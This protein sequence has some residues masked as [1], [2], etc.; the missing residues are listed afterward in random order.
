MQ[1]HILKDFDHAMNTLR[2]EVL[3][4]A[5]LA[6]VNLERAMQALFDRNLELA[7]AVIADDNEVDELER[8]VDQLG[9]DVLVRFHPVASDLRL[10][11]TAMKI[12]MN[13]ER[14]SDHAVNIAKR[15]RK[16]CATPVLPDVNLLEPLYTLADHLLRDAISAFSDRNATL[17]ESLHARD[18]ELDRLHRD[19][20]ATFGS[21]IEESGR[22]EEYLHLIL[23]VRSLERVGDMASNIG[24]NAVFLDVAKDI[25]HDPARKTQQPGN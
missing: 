20:T 9:M 4:M 1:H 24:E 21:R 3:T 11:V 22:S 25:R 17:G 7:N 6:R 13:L 8:R 16:L 12:S 2:G 5:G 15:S 23:I 10:V 18:K 19:A 14:I